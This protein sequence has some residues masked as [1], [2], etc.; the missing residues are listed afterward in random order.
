M[1]GMVEKGVWLWEGI[2]NSQIDITVCVEGGNNDGDAYSDELNDDDDYD[3]DDDDGDE[4]RKW[5]EIYE[6][7]YLVY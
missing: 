6:L 4:K 1:E 7:G 5:K 2:Q 3:D